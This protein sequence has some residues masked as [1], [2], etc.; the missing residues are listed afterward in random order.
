MKSAYPI[1]RTPNGTMYRAYVAEAIGK[2]VNIDGGD[3]NWR[4]KHGVIG[5]YATAE[6]AIA[7]AAQEKNETCTVQVINTRAETE[8]TII[9]FTD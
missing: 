1:Y 5:S 2:N 7:A 3:N 4:G 8:D 9:I 6:E